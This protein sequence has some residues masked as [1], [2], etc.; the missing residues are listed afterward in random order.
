MG[1]ITGDAQRRARPQARTRRPAELGGS[2]L[3]PPGTPS[4][5]GCR[6]PLCPGQ[7]R[8]HPA[9][10][11]LAALAQGSFERLMEF[12]WKRLERR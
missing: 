10:K 8:R 7:Q 9:G 11:R 2:Q 6:W 1:A 3:N 4:Q 5:W 12:K